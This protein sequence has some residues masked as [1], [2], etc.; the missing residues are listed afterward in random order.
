MMVDR[1]ANARNDDRVIEV[2]NRTV[3]TY[4]ALGLTK[5]ADGCITVWSATLT[6]H[7][8]YAVKGR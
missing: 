7:G 5:S 3:S 8:T 4:V 1:C 2:L 6:I